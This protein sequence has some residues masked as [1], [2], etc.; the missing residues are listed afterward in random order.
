MYFEMTMPSKKTPP[1]PGDP[2]DY[3]LVKN[4]EGMHWRRKRGTVTPAK[5]NAGFKASAEAT[6]IIAPA[7]KRILTALRPFLS[8]LDTGRLNNRFSN[9]LRRSLTQTKRLELSYLKGVELQRDHPLEEMLRGSYKIFIDRGTVRIEMAIEKDTIKPL[10][11]LVSDYYFEAVLLHGD[12]NKEKALKTE[13]V[14]SALYPIHSKAKNN[15]VLS[16]SLPKKEDWCLLLK[17]SSLEG[18]EMAVHPK[19]YRMK[20]VGP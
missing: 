17:L 19:H 16:L 18:N 2:T 4:R 5:L 20:V 6:K 9:A 8:G 7:C 12:V 10:N 15:C 14:E 13:T 11:R 1:C 3:M